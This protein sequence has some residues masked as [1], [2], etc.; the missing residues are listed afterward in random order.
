MAEWND[1]EIQEDSI[2]EASLVAPGPAE[3]V[4]LYYA[5]QNQVAPY[6]WSYIESHFFCENL[7]QRPLG[8]LDES[9]INFAEFPHGKGRFLLH[10]T[11]IAFS[12]YLL[13][14]D[15]P[16]KYAER[17]LSYLPE[18]NIYWDSYSRVPEMIAR[19][20][21]RN[22]GF[23]RQ[24]PAEHPFSYILQQPPLAWAWY[25]LLGLAGVYLVF[26]AKRRQRIIP[27]L[28]KNENSSY[29][30]ISTIA[31][32]HFREK[33]YRNLCVQNMR[34]FL[35]QVR[36]RYGLIAQLDQDSLNPRMDEA[37]LERLSQVSE[38]S[39]KQIQNIFTQYAATVQYEPTEDMMVDLHLA[40]ERFFEQA[41]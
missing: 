3:P 21:N 28:P 7:P 13:L 29:E 23:S 10:T 11:P 37:Y 35:A 8:Y 6:N 5:R 20:R 36:D 4:S 19:R 33:N 16:R 39:L 1:Y 9:L 18:G 41:K 2:V 17:I 38:V 26:R 22:S 12:N 40:M 15:A 34:L 14:R 30:F 25:L 24:L 32:L 27:V 31:N